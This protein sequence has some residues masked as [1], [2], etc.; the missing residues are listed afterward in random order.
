MHEL[1][2]IPSLCDSTDFGLNDDKYNHKTGLSYLKRNPKLVEILSKNSILYSVGDKHNGFLFT[3]NNELQ[4]IGYFIRY[5]VKAT[6]LHGVSVTQTALWRNLLDDGSLG[7]THNVI[8]NLLL[9]EY[10][11]ILSDTIQTISGK[12]FWVR[13]MLKALTLGH[14]VGLVDFNN[15]TVH[16]INSTAELRLWSTDTTSAW[17]WKSNKHKRLCFIIY[18]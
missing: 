1:Q 17:A 3:W 15:Q 16:T 10:P 18:R 6:K 13:L 2:V 9:K 12:E 11:A 7:L 4:L 14:T 8:F 5:Q